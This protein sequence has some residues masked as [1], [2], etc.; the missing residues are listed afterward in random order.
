LSEQEGTEPNGVLGDG[1]R[2]DPAA[3]HF[4]IYADDR[5]QLAPFQ[6]PVFL[7]ADNV[8]ERLYIAAFDGTG[9]DKFHDPQHETN[10]GLIS[11]QVEA[12]KALGNGKVGG[13]YIE[14]PGTQQHAPITRVLDGVLGYTVD[15]RAEQMYRLFIE[16]AKRWQH[17]YPDVQIRVA[18]IGFSR[19]GEEAA[20]FARL[21]DERGI[22]DPSGAKYTYDSH[23]Q[24]KHVEY[25]KP[26]L[27]PPHQIAQAVALFDPVGTGSAMHMDRRLPPSVISGI[28]F[29]AMDEHRGLFKSDHI[30][31]PGISP[32]GRFAGVYVPGA[33]S[34]VGG[35]YHRDGVS[36]RTGNFAIDYINGLSDRPIL[37]KNPEPDDPRMNVIHHSEEGV[38]LYRIAPKINRLELGGYNELEVSRHAIKQVPDAY[39][40]EPRDEILNRQFERQAMPNGPV[41]GALGMPHES[42]ASELDQ[43]IDRMYLASQHPDN[44]VWDSAQHQEAQSYLRSPDG[45]QFQQQASS[46]NA[47][48]D[49]QSQAQQQLA[50]QNLQPAQQGFS[51]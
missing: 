7:H 2:H 14:G 31:D 43:W 9:N 27:V 48:W 44:A 3:P 1:V 30:I 16:Q 34:D 50:Q 4:T 37:E 42:P 39:D 13:D 18:G 28:Q 12:L 11:D 41:P 6:E 17:E 5:V 25:T 8:H 26:P 45:Q 46:L 36:I 15:E 32:D 22:Q 49:M 23:H 20:L 29:T 33:H 40:A 21:V 24:I 35:G 47:M 19:G 51:R 10:V 38:L